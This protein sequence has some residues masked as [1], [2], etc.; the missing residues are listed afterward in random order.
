MLGDRSLPGHLPVE[1]QGDVD[2]LPGLVEVRSAHLD[3]VPLEVL[4][5][6]R[7]YLLAKVPRPVRVHA[8]VRADWSPELIHA[9]LPVEVS[10]DLPLHVLEDLVFAQLVEVAGPR[11]SDPARR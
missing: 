6:P 2:E 1:P 9:R 7:R 10:L 5:G 3:Q 11:V 4:I 8:G